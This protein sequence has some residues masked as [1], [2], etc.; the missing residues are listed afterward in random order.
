M[1]EG[2]NETKIFS[3]SFRLYIAL[4]ANIRKKLFSVDNN[5]PTKRKMKW[6][7]IRPWPSW[8]ITRKLRRGFLRECEWGAPS[9][10]QSFPVLWITKVEESHSARN[11]DHRL[12]NF[13]CVASILINQPF[14]THWLTNYSTAWLTSLI[15]PHKDVTSSIG[16]LDVG[17]LVFM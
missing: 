15:Y 13:R 9:L 2:F 6:V 3:A 4:L 16:L 7:S 17:A 8:S 1:K 11:D 14:P 12:M 5:L 10:K